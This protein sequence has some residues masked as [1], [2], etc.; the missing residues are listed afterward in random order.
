MSISPQIDG[1]VQ[2]PPG[3]ANGTTLAAGSVASGPLTFN[4][5]NG[6]TAGASTGFKYTLGPW[7]PSIPRFRVLELTFIMLPFCSLVEAGPSLPLPSEANVTLTWQSRGQPRFVYTAG[8]AL[9]HSPGTQF[10]LGNGLLSQDLVNPI[11]VAP[12]DE[13][14][15]NYAIAFDHDVIQWNFSVG[16][17]YIDPQA[18]NQVAPGV[19]YY[20]TAD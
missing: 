4:T 10:A 2:L 11:S 9:T 18:D 6:T 20:R 7:S 1:A 17:R 8:L 5:S 14:V 12:P 16:A 15:L 13:L 3:G 19:T